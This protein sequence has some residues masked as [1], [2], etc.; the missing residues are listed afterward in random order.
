MSIKMPP[1]I[2]QLQAEAN[3][4]KKEFNQEKLY[5]RMYSF[6]EYYNVINYKISREYPFWRARKCKDKYG[7]TN[8]S[9]IHYPPN[10]NV[11]RVNEPGC[12]MLYL[13]FT[14]FTALHEIG[15]SEGDLVQIA[16]YEILNERPIRCL[17]VGEFD[18]VH[19]SGRAITSSSLGDRL[20]NIL[21]KLSYEVGAS[22]VFMDAF[23]S[24]LLTDESSC[25]SNYLHSRILS[26]ILFL[27]NKSHEALHY[28][29]VALKGSMNLAVKPDIADKHL[30]IPWTAVIKI[31]RKYDYGIYD[32]SIMKSS[33]HINE[34]GTIIW[35]D[36]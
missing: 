31:N 4:M 5:K 6:L 11:G 21:F 16:A 10:P 29:S 34:D 35:R 23:L 33:Q 12:P 8:T 9:K 18:N 28:P 13:S 17:T 14:Q 2:R 7:Y 27:Q 30:Y 26:N 24:A 20:N 25:K 36:V 3:F 22:I 15:A 19:K 1:S 32:F